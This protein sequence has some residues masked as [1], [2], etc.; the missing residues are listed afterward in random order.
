MV[1][2][3]PRLG[4]RNYSKGDTGWD[5]SDLV[6]TLDELAIER[7]P[8]AD[9]PTSG[10]FDDEIY[11]ATDQRIFWKW[12]D[13]AGNWDPVGGAGSEGTPLPATVYREAVSTPVVAMD[14]HLP[15]AVSATIGATE[16]QQCVIPADRSY[17]VDGELVVDG[18]FTFVGL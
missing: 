12:D 4:L 8:V 6:T 1:Q 9:R 16:H 2:Q 15:A 11:Y 10:D 7:G 17:D 3:S 5:H 18:S 13:A 14:T